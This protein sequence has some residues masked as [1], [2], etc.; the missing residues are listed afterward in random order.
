MKVSY[1]ASLFFFC[2]GLLLSN[3]FAFLHPQT[4]EII[5]K[6]IDFGKVREG[7]ILNQKFIVGNSSERP[8]QVGIR[9]TCDCIE[10]VPDRFTV[11]AKTNSEIS[12]TLNTEGYRGRFHEKIFIQS[13]DENNPYFSVNVTCEIISTSWA[14]EITIPMLVFDSPGCLF[15]RE[16][17]TAILPDY[18]RKYGVKIILHEYPLDVPTNYEKLLAME[19]RAGK[20]LNKIPVIFV[21]GDIIGGRDE[22][23]KNLNAL[24]LKYAQIAKHSGPSGVQVPWGDIPGEPFP[25]TAV[26]Q[27]LKILPLI[28]AAVT[29]SVN[30][31]AFAT[32]VFFVTYMSMVLKKKKGEIIL[33]GLFLYPAF[34]YHTFCSDLDFSNCYNL[35]KAGYRRFQKL[36]TC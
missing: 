27:R 14:D 20:T 16:L 6:A 17:K 3:P 8:L 30:P 4:I 1:R 31:C 2:F 26:V 22:I 34:S 19:K 10:V 25:E 33:V 15:C 36:C 5:T 29:D 9:T 21:G 32:I 28:A 12:I 7:V 11:R 18:E 24:I 13:N 35:R 23:V